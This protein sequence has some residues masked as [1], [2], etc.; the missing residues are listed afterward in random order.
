MNDFYG[1][2]LERVEE[3]QEAIRK[4]GEELAP[5]MEAYKAEI[6]R[7]DPGG[8]IKD[9]AE[10]RHIAA[11]G[12]V[13]RVDQGL[14][15]ANLFCQGIISFMT[16]KNLD[17]AEINRYAATVTTTYGGM[18]NPDEPYGSMFADAMAE[19]LGMDGKASTANLGGL[20]DLFGGFGI[21]VTIRQP[22]DAPDE[23][24]VS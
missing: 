13:A 8:P 16:N 15:E 22:E 2:T 24:P 20:A 10:A 18:R 9:D 14:F 21:M 17:R 1:L 6:C 5:I 11:S 3:I 4:L 19:M 12:L 7:Q 23:E